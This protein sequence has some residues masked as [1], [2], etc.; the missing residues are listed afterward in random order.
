MRKPPALTPEEDRLIRTH[1]AR[2]E[3]LA[4]GRCAP[5]SDDERSFVCVF[6]DR[7]LRAATADE[8]AYGK[9]LALKAWEA[10]HGRSASA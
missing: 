7:T 5:A 9:Y 3:R 8:I 4:A 1:L 6:R 10:H 2:Y